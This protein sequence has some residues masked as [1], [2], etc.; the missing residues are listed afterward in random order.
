MCLFSSSL[1]KQNPLSN[2][3]PLAEAFLRSTSRNQ[4]K[5]GQDFVALASVFSPNTTLPLRAYL[6]PLLQDYSFETSLFKILKSQPES[7]FF[8]QAMRQMSIITAN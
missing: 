5:S 8:N 2:P 6:K 1:F 7:T 3:L 4:R